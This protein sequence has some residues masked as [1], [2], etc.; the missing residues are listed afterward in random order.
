MAEQS[1]Y[2]FSAVEAQDILASREQGWVGFTQFVTYGV[3]A[4][5][6]ILLLLFLF[7]A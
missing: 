3:I 2:D 4:V 6:A 7:V 1:S 5:V